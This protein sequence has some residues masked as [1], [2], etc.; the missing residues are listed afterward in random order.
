MQP[1]REC[2]AKFVLATGSILFKNQAVTWISI[3][4]ERGTSSVALASIVKQLVLLV[5]RLAYQRAF[6]DL[7]VCFYRSRPVHL[8]RGGCARGSCQGRLF[9]WNPRLRNLQWCRRWRRTRV[10]GRL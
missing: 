2:Q 5:L 8:L 4:C 9:P 1:L 10:R 7:F 6:P 3:T